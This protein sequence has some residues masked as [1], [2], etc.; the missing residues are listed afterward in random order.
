MP[1]PLWPPVPALAQR[2][3]P[4][5]ALHCT[6]TSKRLFLTASQ[7]PSSRVLLLQLFQAIS[8]TVFLLPVLFN[9]KYHLS[10]Y[11]LTQ[12]RSPQEHTAAL[13]ED[14]PRVWTKWGAEGPSVPHPASADFINDQDKSH[15]PLLTLFSTCGS[16]N[17]SCLWRRLQRKRALFS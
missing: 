8:Y 7:H 4:G 5:T 15:S 13:R 11:T 10:L 9:G 14:E 3:L 2:L 6:N 16:R 12:P 17:L 1:R